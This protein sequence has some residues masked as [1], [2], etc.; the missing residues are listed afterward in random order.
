MIGHLLSR[1]V[2]LPRFHCASAPA[3]RSQCPLNSI[4][5]VATFDSALSGRYR[6][7]SFLRH[8]KVPDAVKRSVTDAALSV[9]V[10]ST[11][12]SLTASAVMSLFGKLDAKVLNLTTDLQLV[13]VDANDAAFHR[14]FI[15]RLQSAFRRSRYRQ[16]RLRRTN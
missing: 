4:L 15:G 12:S 14:E 13:R 8:R 2:I 11:A 3:R 9:D 7:N 1:V 10:T 6:E 5:H 16:L